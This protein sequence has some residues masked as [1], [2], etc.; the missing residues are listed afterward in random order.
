M[1]P[2]F[3]K[4]PIKSQNSFSI[5]HERESGFGTVWHYHP[6]LELHY[7]VKGNGVRFIGDNISNFSDGELILLGQNLPHTW[8]VEA[9]GNVGVEVIIIHFLPDCLG[10]DLL[11]LPEAYLIPKLYEKAKKGL[12]INGEAKQKVIE[13]MRFAVDAQNL[14][15]LIALLSIL[16]ILAETEETE[17]ITSAHAFYKSNDSETLRLNKV[18]AYTLSN[19]KNQ[20]ALQEVAAIANLGVTSFC[21]YFKLMTKKTYNDFLVEIRISHACR[22]LIEDRYTIEVICFECGFNNISNFYRHFKS[23]TGMTPL[24]YKRKYLFKRKPEVLSHM[25]V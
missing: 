21:R 4:V 8:R 5:R 11:N 13:L 16:K 6:E 1:K 15:R 24:E 20:I 23:V 25:K 2:H 14:D 22:F 3:H 18:Y 10:A 19:Y 12:V 17:T 9:G 7:L